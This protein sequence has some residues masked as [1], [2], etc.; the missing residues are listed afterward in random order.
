MAVHQE[1]LAVL[2][3]EECSLTSQ[4]LLFKE[5]A[6]AVALGVPTQ[7][8]VR[9]AQVVAEQVRQVH[10]QRLRL[11]ALALQVAVAVVDLAGITQQQAALES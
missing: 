11:L 7:P 1:I 2:V 9:V 4:V 8:E 3:E 6:V 10:Q 5:V